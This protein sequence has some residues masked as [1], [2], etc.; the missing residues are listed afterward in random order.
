MPPDEGMAFDPETE[1]DEANIPSESDAESEH[2]DD[3]TAGL[4]IAP[5]GLL[6]R[7]RARREDDLHRHLAVLGDVAM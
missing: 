7:G 6:R 2:M 1:G 5:S 3:E 4:C